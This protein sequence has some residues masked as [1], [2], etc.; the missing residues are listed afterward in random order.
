MQYMYI[1]NISEHYIDSEK[2]AARVQMNGPL[3]SYK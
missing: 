1:N 3:L 2:S